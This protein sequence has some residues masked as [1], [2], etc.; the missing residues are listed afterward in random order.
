MSGYERTLKGMRR[1]REYLHV[2]EPDDTLQIVENADSWGCSRM[3]PS[4]AF[5]NPGDQTDKDRAEG[6]TY[7]DKGIWSL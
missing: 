2:R 4:Q 7:G 1:E 5:P 3:K 6:K